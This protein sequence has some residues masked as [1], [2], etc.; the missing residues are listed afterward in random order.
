M[1]LLLLPSV[2]FLYRSN[3]KQSGFEVSLL[4]MHSDLRYIALGVLLL[5][6]LLLV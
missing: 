3:G 5:L 2:G 4:N 1:Q 6:L